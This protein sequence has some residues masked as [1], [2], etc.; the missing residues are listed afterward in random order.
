VKPFELRQETRDALQLSEQ[1]LR[2]EKIFAWIQYERELY[3][4]NIAN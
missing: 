2:G 3:S 1:S 4:K